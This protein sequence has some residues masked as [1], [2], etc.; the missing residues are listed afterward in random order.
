M[1]QLQ[2]DCHDKAAAPRFLMRK[3]EKMF[4]NSELP[5]MLLFLFFSSAKTFL[6]KLNGK[7]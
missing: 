3:P 2:P 4:R 7:P 5:K 1:E 6:V